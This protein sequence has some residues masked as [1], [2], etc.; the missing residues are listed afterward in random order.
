[1]KNIDKHLAIVFTCLTAV[2]FVAA[3]TNKDFLYWAFERHQ[4]Q[5]SWY[6]RPLFII[7]YCYF[8]YKKSWA[9][10]TGTIFLLF[11]SMFWFPVPDVINPDVAKFLVMEK[12]WLSSTWS[13]SEAIMG[14]TI[15]LFFAILATAFWYKSVRIGL[16]IVIFAAVGKM[17]WSVGVEEQAGQ[18]V[19]APAIVGLILCCGVIYFGYRRLERSKA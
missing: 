3:F 4:N 15:P 8:A 5:L 7:P 1:M 13:T 17:L 10:I 11:T 9:G 18:S 12:K 6:A 14:L 16:A 19:L 2:F